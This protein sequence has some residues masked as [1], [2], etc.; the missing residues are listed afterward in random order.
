MSGCFHLKGWDWLWHAGSKEYGTT[1]G[2]YSPKEY[3]KIINRIA[4]D[5]SGYESLFLGASNY[6]P[7]NRNWTDAEKVNIANINL[8]KFIGKGLSG[9]TASYL[10]AGAGIYA[11]DR[12]AIVSG[13]IAPSSFNVE[14]MLGLG[15]LMKEG[16]KVLSTIALKNIET[17]TYSKVVG[18]IEQSALERLRVRLIGLNDRNFKI[19]AIRAFGSR[20]KGTFTV[21]SDVDIVIIT[22]Q[23]S[24]MRMDKRIQEILES[25]S[26]DFYNTTKKKLDLNIF[27]SV[28]IG[29]RTLFK[30][31]ELKSF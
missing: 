24:E 3:Q 29:P 10:I 4:R 5:L 16:L 7:T 8:G 30:K 20:T 13:Y 9:Y 25:I 14:D 27:K 17:T 26:T 1:A 23:A 15:L 28:E 22:N 19:D 11:S 2:W 6:A 18:G 12:A 21:S 31:E